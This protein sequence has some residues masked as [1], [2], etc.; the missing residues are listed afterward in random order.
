MKKASAQTQSKAKNLFR[1]MF[2]PNLT[3][4]FWPLKSLYFLIAYTLFYCLLPTRLIDDAFFAKVQKGYAPRIL[5]IFKNAGRN[6]SLTKRGIADGVIYFSVA[7]VFFGTL[8]ALGLWGMSQFVGTAAAQSFFKAAC[9]GGDL[10]LNFIG[11]LFGTANPGNVSPESCGADLNTPAS[12]IFIQDAV[13]SMLDF[14]SKAM[15]VFATFI[16]IYQIISIVVET[17][18]HGQAFGQRHS[19]LWTPL[20]LVFGIGL[21]IPVQQNL[22]IGQWVIIRAAEGGSAFASNAWA[23]Y[24]ETT[25]GVLSNLPEPVAVEINSIVLGYFRNM[26]CQTMNNI[27]VARNLPDPTVQDGIYAAY[28]SSWAEGEAAFRS[29]HNAAMAEYYSTA[30]RY[31]AATPYGPVMSIWEKDRE[32]FLYS[33]PEHYVSFGPLLQSNPACGQ[34]KMVGSSSM[35]ADGTIAV[36]NAHKAG[37]EGLKEDLGDL[38]ALTGLALATGL[39]E[40]TLPDVRKYQIKASATKYQEKIREALIGSTEQAEE[41][42]GEQLEQM[43]A[44]NGWVAAPAFYNYIARSNADLHDFATQVPSYKGPNLDRIGHLTGG[45]STY[46]ARMLENIYSLD[47][48]IASIAK[49]D[50][51]VS[52]AYDNIAID[53]SDEADSGSTPSQYVVDMFSQIYDARESG[54]ITWF[55]FDEAKPLAE[56]SS[57]GFSLIKKSMAALA[58]STLLSFLTGGGTALDIFLGIMMTVGLTAG[59]VLAYLVPLMPFIRMISGILAWLVS[60]VE[61]VIAI[62]L[63]AIGHLTS[64][65]EGLV[66]NMAQPAYF[67]MLQIILRP[68]LMIVG[69]VMSIVSLSIMVFV[70]NQLFISAVVDVS[71]GPDVTIGAVSQFVYSVIYCVI[72]YTLANTAFKLIDVIPDE[73]LRWIGQRGFRAAEVGDPSDEIQ[74]KMLGAMVVSNKIASVGRS[75]GP[76]VQKALN[77]RKM[78]NDL[79]NQKPSLPKGSS[80]GGSNSVSVSER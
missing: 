41:S 78:R 37:L 75:M 52:K 71:N 40:A 55:T 64:Q 79:K 25:K 61:G 31:P 44:D 54:S 1:F 17:A 74:G 19:A 32:T 68:F 22:S 49:A 5:E 66:G 67:M 27:Y 77:D 14:Y 15:L 58:I 57:F 16:V 38:A 59:F 51:E 60:I 43:T 80:G 39:T 73:C 36:Y 76:S 13:R 53:D 28:R 7:G 20:R 62:P 30:G 18:W 47:N 69:M 23:K 21:L 26:T 2:L 63:V 35:E 12:L 29:A 56:L 11:M 3:K 33:I 6:L 50:P 65:G 34:F 48:Y 24:V 9:E 42:L 4:A 46:R 10:G 70:L 8:S 72:A 45:G